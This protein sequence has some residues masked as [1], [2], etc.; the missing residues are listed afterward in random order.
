VPFDASTLGARDD[1]RLTPG[2]PC[3]GGI[4]QSPSDAAGFDTVHSFTA[5]ITGDYSIRASAP[6]DGINPVLYTASSC[7]LPDEGGPVVVSCGDAAN[8]VNNVADQL[9]VPLSVGQ[10]IF[11]FVD[12]TGT[13]ATHIGGEY[14]LEVR[15]RA[16]EDEPNG[17][18]AT[19]DSRLCGIQSDI[20][21]ASDVDFFALGTPAAASRV[22][23]L[24][25]GPHLNGTNVDMRVTTAA[26]TLERDRANADTLF[27]PNMPAIGGTPL[28]GV[29]SYLR[30]NRDEADQERTE[31]RLYSVVQP[32]SSLA[33]LERAPNDILALADSDGS[34]YFSGTLAGPAPS[35]DVDLY[36]TSLAARDEIFVGLDGD[37]LRNNT[38]I[39]AKMAL[40]DAAGNVLLEVSDGGATSSTASGAGSLT[41]TTPFSP[42][43]ALVYRAKTAGT[44]YLRVEIGTTS[45]TGPGAGD[46]LLSI[47]KDC[48]S[49]DGDLLRDAF[50]SGGTSVWTLTSP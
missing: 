7:P 32:S 6:G 33:A 38:P 49:G 13:D 19:A 11:I 29:A 14:R 46:Y 37:P 5:P 22:F 41:A 8:R 48:V 35:T 43:E 25:D 42:A 3:Y 1:Y 45:S 40:L 39:N 31:N 10:T 12:E 20:A 47:A 16:R 34:N 36:R 23:A 21:P 27:G 17:T 9:E 30:V 2:S 18:P 28:T 44:H 50:E 15:R 4:A 24:L 26:D